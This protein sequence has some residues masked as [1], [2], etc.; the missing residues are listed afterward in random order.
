MHNN[1]YTYVHTYIDI[2]TIM[3]II[4]LNNTGISTLTIFSYYM[5]LNVHETITLCHVTQKGDAAGKKILHHC[6]YWIFTK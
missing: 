2:I 5:P 1:L 4:L 3:L 6:Y